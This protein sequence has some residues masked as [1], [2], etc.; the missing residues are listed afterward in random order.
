M[1]V[2]CA[3][4]RDGL[5]HLV[6]PVLHGGSPETAIVRR[7]LS[8]VGVVGLSRGAYVKNISLTG[9]ALKSPLLSLAPQ[10]DHA[11][12]RSLV[13]RF[14]GVVLVAAAIVFRTMLHS[15][16]VDSVAEGASRRGPAPGPVQRVTE[17]LENKE[18]ATST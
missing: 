18:P 11:S 12:S 2:P 8:R 15:P 9:C 5:L 13:Y 16:A 1:A 4:A 6:A 7:Q 17:A 14:S 10:H 3:P